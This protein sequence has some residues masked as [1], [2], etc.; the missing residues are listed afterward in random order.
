MITRPQENALR[1]DM[2]TAM[3][4]LALHLAGG[5][6]AQV[7][8]FHIT[9]DG[10]GTTYH[11]SG[12]L[13][14]GTDPDGSVTDPD[15]R[16]HHTAALRTRACVP[17]RPLVR[18]PCR[19]A[20]GRPPALPRRA[21]LACWSRRSGMVAGMPRAAETA[22]VDAAGVALAAHPARMGR[23]LLSRLATRPMLP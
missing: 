19:T 21:P 4:A 15:G 12:T 8:N 13:W 3:R 16:F 1:D 17:S 9:E 11:E 22:A 20:G 6:A 23:R 5:D 10:L 7:H 2:N 14:M 18:P